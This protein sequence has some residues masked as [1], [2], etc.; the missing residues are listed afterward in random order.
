MSR[1]KGIKNKPKVPAKLGRP[2]VN[3]R[4][5]KM[6][7]PFIKKSVE[8]IN[9]EIREAYGPVTDNDR[10][11]DTYTQINT[12]DAEDCFQRFK[13]RCVYCDK[14]LSYLNRKAINSA[15]LAFYVPLKVGGEARADNLIIICIQCRS[16]YRATRKMRE[17][18]T[19]IDSFADT[20]EALF[21]AVKE[22]A[23]EEIRTQIKNRL[24]IRLSDV[25]TC[26]R[27][28][29]TPDWVPE[30]MQIIMEGDNTIGELLEGMAEGK[31]KK[32]EIT[33]TVKQVV[34]T[35]QYNIVRDPDKI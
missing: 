2:V 18:I 6:N 8:E 28:V 12:A 34:T 3:K 14:R 29:T 30:R 15:R 7:S 10:F 35:K 23:S 26:M 19:G 22:G 21:K 1:P 31:D 5:Q 25:A 32:K 17:D 33:E 13:G 4:R 9:L 20:C 24:N 11:W 16:N 27:Y